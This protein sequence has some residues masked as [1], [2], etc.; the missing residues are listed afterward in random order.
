MYWLNHIVGPGDVVYD[1]GANVGAY[2]LYAAKRLDS[3]NPEG[4]V[5]AFEPAFSNFFS[6][7]RNIELNHLHDVVVPFAL[8]FG[9]GRYETYFFLRSTQA[10]AALHGVSEP[11]SEG[12]V[13]EPKFRQGVN[14]ISLDSFVKNTG[15]LFQGP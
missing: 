5:Y 12:A 8:A 14:V 6:L 15:T 1:I 3:I 2:S 7:C 13:F 9:S 10:G 4:K 11:S